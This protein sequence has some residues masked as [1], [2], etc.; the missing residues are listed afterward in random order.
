MCYINC[1]YQYFRIA[2]LLSAKIWLTVLLLAKLAAQLCYTQW[3]TI[4][5]SRQSINGVPLQAVNNLIL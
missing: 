5:I 3:G 4:F 2:S 1:L